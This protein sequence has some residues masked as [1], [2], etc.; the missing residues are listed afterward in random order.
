MGSDGTSTVLPSSLNGGSD[1][2]SGNTFDCAILHIYTL[3]E[4]K[5][6][7]PKQRYF[8]ASNTIDLLNPDKLL[9]FGFPILIYTLIH[10]IPFSFLSTE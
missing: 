6:I 1:N 10:I 9:F 7:T 5:K 2:E 4:P 3:I 8:S